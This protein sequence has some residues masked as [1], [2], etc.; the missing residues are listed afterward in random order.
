[1]RTHT[2]IHMCRYNDRAPLENHHLAAAFTLLRRPE[3]AFLSHLPKADT[4]RMRKMVGG[5]RG[6]G[7]GTSVERDDVSKEFW[8][9]AR[10]T[11]AVPGWKRRKRCRGLG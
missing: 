6:R 11:R 4:D 7:R 1:M 10:R 8:E 2:L 3:Y 5:G 9:T